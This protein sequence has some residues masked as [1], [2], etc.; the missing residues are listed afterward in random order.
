MLTKV[1]EGDRFTYGETLAI[2]V[3]LSRALAQKFDVQRGWVFVLALMILD[4]LK[5]LHALS[6]V[7]QRRA[8]PFW[9][10]T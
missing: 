9:G 6:G 10:L 4:V 5:H 1:Y 8:Y 2:A 3:A 7:L